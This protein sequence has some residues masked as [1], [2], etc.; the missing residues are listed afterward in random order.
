MHFDVVTSKRQHV[1]AI[2][3]S[4]AEAEAKEYPRCIAGSCDIPTLTIAVSLAKLYQSNAYTGKAAGLEAYRTIGRQPISSV[5]LA[6]N[7]YPAAS[8]TLPYRRPFVNA[9]SL[10]RRSMGW[11]NSAGDAR[12]D[13][14]P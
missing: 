2:T 11:C 12:P 3:I 13:R 7:F 14:R 4:R 8:H 5:I 1:L 10:R 9:D 6:S